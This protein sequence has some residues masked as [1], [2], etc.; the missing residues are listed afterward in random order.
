MKVKEGDEDAFRIL[1]ER[2]RGKL[3]K[4]AYGMIGNPSL[5]E[6]VVQDVFVKLFLSRKR[7]RPISS[8][9][10]YIYK[11]AHN[12]CLNF[13]KSRR[14][15]EMSH[16]SIEEMKG[17]EPSFNESEDEDRERIEKLKRE[18]KNLP[19]R[20]KTAIELVLLEGMSYEEIAHVIGCS[21]NSAKILV[22]RAKEKLMERL[23][24]EKKL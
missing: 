4:Y 9:R 12:V 16:L 2:Y 24:D 6:D 1:F 21:Y 20:Q 19:E 14:Y 7:Y 15:R 17:V 5:A 18:F 22:F 23:K 11:I 13:L 3:M 8:F 10:T